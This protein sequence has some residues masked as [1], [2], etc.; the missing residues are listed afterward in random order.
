L[1]AVD[2]GN[3]KAIV[4][5]ITIAELCIGYYNTD[6]IKEK[7]EFIAG[8]Y[9]NQHYKIMDLNL[10]I[11]DKSGEI[12]NISHM[13]LPDSII[14]ASSILEHASCLITND[15]GFDKAKKFI[16]VY[17]SEEFVKEFVKK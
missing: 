16:P 14:I 10:K 5:T 7:D 9:S 12:K 2:D 1:E 13:K 17:T 6:E 4:S 11:A 8:L 3:L 15:G